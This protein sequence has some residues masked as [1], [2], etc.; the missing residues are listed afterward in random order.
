MRIRRRGFTLIELIV[1]LTLIG[2]LVGLA[3]PEFRNS[4]KRAKETILKEDLFIFRKLIG[5]Y[6]QDKGKYPLTL[7]ALVE[8][9]YLRSMPEDPLTKS[10]TT[11]VEIREQ[12]SLEDYM[13]TGQLGV[14]D[15]R[16]GSE[17][18]ALDGTLYNTW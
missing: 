13:P 4:I 1:V 17:A 2:I 15:V 5:Q 7:Q 3:L 16:S 12:P 14:V 11:W 8:E 18:K 9:G 6:Y 10:A